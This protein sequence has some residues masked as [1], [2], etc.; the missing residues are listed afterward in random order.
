MA[1]TAL[2]EKGSFNASEK[3]TFRVFA[4]TASGRLCRRHQRYAPWTAATYSI[5]AT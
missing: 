1:F 2:F 5:Y 3:P 4:D